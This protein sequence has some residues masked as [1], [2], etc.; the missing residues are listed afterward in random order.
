MAFSSL[1]HVVGFLLLLC[2]WSFQCKYQIK[3]DVFRVMYS[4]DC[5]SASAWCDEMQY[6]NSLLL[7]VSQFIF[8]S[9]FIWMYVPIL[10]CFILINSKSIKFTFFSIYS[11]SFELFSVLKYKFIPVDFKFSFKLFSLNILSFLSQ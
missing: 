1:F 11:I 9:S 5:W 3:I 10:F 2:V 6:D 8:S 4:A 7:Y